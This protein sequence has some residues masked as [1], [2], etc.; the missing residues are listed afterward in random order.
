MITAVAGVTDSQSTGLVTSKQQSGDQFA[1]MLASVTTTGTA[2]DAATSA[3]P[4]SILGSAA[5]AQLFATPQEEQDFATDLNNRLRAAG[6]DTSQPIQLQVQGDGSVVAKEG[7]PGKQQIDAVFAADPA[8]ANE[9]RKIANTEETKA[10]V[11][12]DL[13]YQN[14][15]EDLGSAAQSALWQRYAGIIG[16]NLYRG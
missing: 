15:A 6:V 16:K 13:A 2:A 3:A 4:R 8:L 10:I 14:Q 12:A 11:R 7:T 9:Y 1:Q 5:A